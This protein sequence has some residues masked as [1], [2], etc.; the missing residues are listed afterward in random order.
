MSMPRLFPQPTTADHRAGHRTPRHRMGDPVHH[1]FTYPDF[2][3]PDLTYPDFTYPSARARAAAQ[4]RR[5]G[6]VRTE[7]AVA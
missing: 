1:D 5:R 6:V 3:Y 4:A 2:T 7:E